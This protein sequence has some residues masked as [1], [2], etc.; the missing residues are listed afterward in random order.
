[1]KHSSLDR[2]RVPYDQSPFQRRTRQKVATLTAAPKGVCEWI[3]RRSAVVRTES[4]MAAICSERVGGSS[5]ATLA[6]AQRGVHWRASAIVRH[7]N[8]STLEEP[9]CHVLPSS[10]ATCRHPATE[11]QGYEWR[12]L[13]NRE[14][15][16]QGLYGLLPTLVREPKRGVV[17]RDREARPQDVVGA[18]C[19]R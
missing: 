4:N 9:C 15:A 14:R 8:T 1:M 3:P 12:M 16:V 19:L 2:Q 5:G 18:H 13:A 6:S 17:H 11:W 7:V 10:F